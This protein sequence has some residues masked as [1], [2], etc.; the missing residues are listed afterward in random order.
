MI[1]GREIFED[2]KENKHGYFD[3]GELESVKITIYQFDAFAIPYLVEKCF[4][5]HVP[6]IREYELM[7]ADSNGQ[8]IREAI[9]WLDAYE[10]KKI[11]EVK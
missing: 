11:E 8:V 5:S 4:E 3:R 10:F 9:K 1:K 2:R 7:K 6:T